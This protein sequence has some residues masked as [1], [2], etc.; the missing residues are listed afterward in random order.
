M[1][2][3][4]DS[5]A[6]SC[7][8]R[9]PTEV[10]PMTAPRDSQSPPPPPPPPANPPPPTKPSQPTVPLLPPARP[11]EDP[12]RLKPAPSPQTHAKGSTGGGESLSVSWGG[13]TNAK[14]L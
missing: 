5:L 9:V 13:R 8:T 3:P 1:G 11:T 4:L 7:Y 10:R 6:L 12:H 14:V 2:F